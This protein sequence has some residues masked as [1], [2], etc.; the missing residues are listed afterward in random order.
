MKKLE[1]IRNMV[2]FSIALGITIC[3]SILICSFSG[4]NV[5]ANDAFSGGDGT[6]EN[7][8]QIT[9]KEQLN[10][11]RNHLKANFILMNDI[12]F[13][14]TDFEEG[15]E[16]YNGGQ[17]WKSIGES[18]KYDQNY[19]GLF[20]GVFDGN[21]HKIVNLKQN[22]KVV[23]NDYNGGFF[24]D[25]GLRGIVKNLTIENA[26]INE[27][28]AILAA[29]NYGYILNCKTTGSVLNTNNGAG[30]GI[31][32]YNCGLVAKC[33][34]TADISVL[35]S[36]VTSSYTMLGG[37]AASSPGEIVDCINYG[38]ITI[39]NGSYA[40]AGGIAG[41]GTETYYCVNKGKVES[42][43]YAAGIVAMAAGFRGHACYNTGEIISD[44]YAGGVLGGE[45][46]DGTTMDQCYNVGNISGEIVGGLAAKKAGGSLAAVK[47]TNSFFLNT[48]PNGFAG[49][50]KYDGMESF[51]LSEI[52]SKETFKGFDFDNIWNITDY[53]PVLKDNIFDYYKKHDKIYDVR[54]G[55]SF[56]GKLDDYGLK[57]QYYV[58]DKI[59]VTGAIFEADSR[60][61]EA[62]VKGN[63]YLIDGEIRSYS[64]RFDADPIYIDEN[65]IY[66]QSEEDSSQ[67]VYLYLIDPSEITVSGFDTSKP[68]TKKQ[69]VTIGFYRYTGTYKIE[70][71]E[72][73]HVHIEDE[74]TIV[75]EA[76]CT[77]GGLKEFKCTGCGELL[78]TEVINPL[79]HKWGEGVVTKEA[80][81]T[82]SG[83]K[84]F[85]C[86]RCETVK[87]EVINSLGHKWN[88]GVVTK[89]PTI[90][91]EGEKTFTCDN[92]GAT[93][94]EK[95]AKLPVQ[96]ASTMVK[97]P[98][99]QV[100]IVSKK[101]TKTVVYKFKNLKKKKVSFRIGA[102]AKT[103]IT[104]TVTKKAKKYITVLKNG[105][106]IVKKG[107]KKGT[108]KITV[109]AIETNEYLQ[110]RKIVTIKVK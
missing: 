24:E 74:G 96:S 44:K 59:D 18:Y 19:D 70:V 65:T 69:K 34:N 49:K 78:R 66:I 64:N 39:K 52:D 109:K 43:N 12:V 95:M 72:K 42:S 37:I 10:E 47:A 90:T 88:Q 97:K 81:C 4:I 57:S 63:Q 27:G 76:T 80:T 7:P 60:H 92:C 104:Y 28:D 25:I 75:K 35:Y 98:K 9:T 101:A 105:K 55:Q 46:E 58:G 94:I 54:F 68:T 41:G 21:Q 102:K 26:H 15:G 61:A 107:C 13:E 87:T 40:F 77:T 108:Y 99:K 73:P 106:V 62:I 93:R 85:K 51:D 103:K 110:T 29:S 32:N 83:L 50:D 79:G 17:G 14:D 91:T 56:E 23:K 8:Y 22:I 38:N 20:S 11:V 36:N 1:S 5:R 31:T 6:V 89:Q 86:T 67:Y 71:L 53:G 84:E 82:T 33:E 3:L 100:I 30:G 2:I 16:F 48:T 45:M